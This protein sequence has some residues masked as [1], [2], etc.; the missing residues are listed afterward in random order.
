MTDLPLVSCLCPTYNRPYWLAQSMCY[1]ERQ[2]YPHKELVILDDSPVPYAGVL[3]PAVRYIHVEQRCSSLGAKFNRLVEEA[4]GDFMLH[5]GDD[6]WMSPN[7]ITHAVSP[8]LAGEAD[9][10]AAA[11]AGLHVFDVRAWQRWRL[12][13]HPDLLR[14]IHDGAL[15]YPKLWWEREGKY[16]DHSRGEGTVLIQAFRMAFARIMALPSEEHY[17]YVRHG[18]N[19]WRSF[20]PGRYGGTHL[21][22]IVGEEDKDGWPIQEEDMTFYRHI[23]QLLESK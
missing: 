12:V 3:S 9:A 5:W 4:R 11:L 18:M 15:C 1:F 13:P 10:T 21:W 19:E 14:Y 16:P 8:L 22:E 17:V 23:L 20:E 7:H 2:D 6:D